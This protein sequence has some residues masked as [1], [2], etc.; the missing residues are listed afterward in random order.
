ML[1]PTR[2]GSK[3]KTTYRIQFCPIP[4][5]PYFWSVKTIDS[6]VAVHSSSGV[7]V[8]M[9]DS[10]EIGPG[11]DKFDLETQFAKGVEQLATRK[12]SADH[13]HVGLND[14]LDRHVCQEIRRTV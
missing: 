10:T 11:F 4:G 8:P 6:I 14:L 13:Q 3:W 7:R 9:P 5:F 2:R 12:A 1:L